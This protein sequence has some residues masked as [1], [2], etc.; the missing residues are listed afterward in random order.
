MRPGRRRAQHISVELARSADELRTRLRPLLDGAEPQLD[1]LLY[2]PDYH[3]RQPGSAGLDPARIVDASRRDAFAAI[4]QELTAAQA[5]DA[6]TEPARLQALHRFFAD[7]LELVPD[8]QAHIGQAD[9][10]TTRLSGGLT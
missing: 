8:V 3:V 6:P 4:V 9:D 5:G 10:L 1:I 7:I 2:C